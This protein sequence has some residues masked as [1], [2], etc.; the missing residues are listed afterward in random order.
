MK[1]NKMAGTYYRYDD[2]GVA[3]TVWGFEG[4]DSRKIV[5]NDTEFIPQVN[6]DNEADVKKIAGIQTLTQDQYD[7]Y[8]QNISDWIQFIPGSRPPHKPR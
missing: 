4:S 7:A 1:K 5:E 2:T 8:A 6:T 3:T